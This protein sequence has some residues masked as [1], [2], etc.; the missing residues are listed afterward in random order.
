LSFVGSVE[1]IEQAV[2][3]HPAAA[4]FLVIPG[5]IEFV[6]MQSRIHSFLKWNPARGDAKHINFFES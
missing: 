3:V 6:E 1:T 2:P 5:L 4:R